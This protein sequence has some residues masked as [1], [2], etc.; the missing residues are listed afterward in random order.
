M[1]IKR[2]IFR[3][4]NGLINKFGILLSVPEVIHGSPAFSGA[5]L[6]ARRQKDMK[7]YF[8]ILQGVKGGGSREWCA[9]GVRYFNRII[10]R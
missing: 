8:D 9:L 7:Y 2:S 5:T 1:N 10:S 3:S 4:V 6:W